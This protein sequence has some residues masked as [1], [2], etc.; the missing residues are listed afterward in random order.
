M[1]CLGAFHSDD[2]KLRYSV[3][4][5]EPGTD[6]GKGEKAD[7]VAFSSESFD[8]GIP[9]LYTEGV[10]GWCIAAAMFGVATL[11]LSSGSRPVR[12]WPA[13]TG[14]GL[15]FGGLLGCGLCVFVNWMLA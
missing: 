8:R 13:L 6:C 12:R 14:I 2:G 15:L 4:D 1:E 9:A 10:R 7:A 3:E 11:V 5:Y